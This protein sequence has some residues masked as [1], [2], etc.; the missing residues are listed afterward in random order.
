MKLDR[1]SILEI[2]R[3]AI[4]ERA[5]C[6]MNE[7]MD[8]I[9]DVNTKAS[10]KRA[11]TITVELTPDDSRTQIGINAIAKVTKKEPP[12]PIVTSVTV[13]PDPET[14]EVIA[15]ENTPQ[16][17]GQLGMDGGEQESPVALRLIKT[18]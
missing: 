3:G 9:Q 12:T 15:V 8:N 5:D 2:A 18:A 14:G 17:P 4:L 10:K 13:M 16:V 1:K 7:L 11:M 6:V